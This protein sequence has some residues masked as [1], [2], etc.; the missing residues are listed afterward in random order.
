MGLL[1]LCCLGGVPNDF[2]HPFP[3]AKLESNLLI[4]QMDE[5]T[6]R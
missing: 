5:P 3:S 4:Y 2:E 1:G 6:F